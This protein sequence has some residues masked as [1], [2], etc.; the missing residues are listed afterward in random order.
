MKEILILV[1][2]K[3]HTSQDFFFNNY[4]IIVCVNCVTQ[5]EIVCSINRLLPLPQASPCLVIQT[6]RLFQIHE[7]EFYLIQQI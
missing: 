1:N 4:K 3:E 6:L 5:W 7:R 2:E